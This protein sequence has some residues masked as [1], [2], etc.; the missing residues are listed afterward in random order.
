MRAFLIVLLASLTA[1]STPYNPR[2]TDGELT[3]SRRSDGFTA[4][5][6]GVST[7]LLSDGG[8]AIM[9]DGFFTRP[10]IIEAL[11]LEPSVVAINYALARG[12]VRKQN[13]K[14]M[15]VAHAHH[16]HV[17]DTATVAD[18]LG[19]RIAGSA[20]T[21]RVVLSEGFPQART[22]QIGNTDRIKIDSFEVEVF[23]SPHSPPSFPLPK[24]D[25]DVAPGFKMPASVK[26]Y[27]EGGN[28]SFLVK[29]R[30]RRILIHPSANYRAG[31]FAGVK[32]DVVFLGIGMLGQQSEEFAR[33][34]WETVVTTTGARL[35]IP[36]HWDDLQNPIDKPPRFTGLP[37]NVV[38]ALVLLRKVRDAAAKESKDSPVEIKFMP[39]FESVDV[40][41]EFPVSP[42]KQTGEQAVVQEPTATDFRAMQPCPRE[43]S[44]SP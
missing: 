44:S 37:D 23:R 3:T 12:K 22:F 15:L 13:V 9:T 36:I 39:F 38:R 33:N 2:L 31:T 29:H 42:D 5:F 10:K 30:G 18:K 16:D 35:V 43:S 32:A 20:S 4:R 34:Y 14:V 7:I 25:G 19:A 11:A 26:A 40:L 1:C 41:A 6:F 8:T 27:Q 21:C 28:F 24:I 17:L